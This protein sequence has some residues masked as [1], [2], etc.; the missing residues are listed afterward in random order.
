MRRIPNLRSFVL[1]AWCRGAALRFSGEAFERLA[2]AGFFA[3]TVIGPLRSQPLLPQTTP[4]PGIPGYRFPERE[5]TLLR[6]V[7]GSNSADEG[8]RAAATAKIR[9]HGWGLWTALTMETAQVFGGQRLRIFET[10]TTP[11][12]LASHPDW[13]NTAALSQRQRRRAPLRRLAQFQARPETDGPVAPMAS[14]SAGGRIVGFVKFD[15]TAADHLLA[16][17]LLHT[18]TLDALLQNGAQQVPVFPATALAVKSVF[19]IIK[20]SDLVDG[21]YYSLKAWPGPPDLPQPWGPAQWQGCVWIDLL[22]GGTGNGA[23]DEQAWADGGSRTTDTTY[24]LSS[25]INYRLSADDA[26]ALN[27]E[28]PGTGA[29]VG[30]HAI[31]VAMHIS[32]R[33]LARWTWQTF[34]WTPAPEAPNAPSS[35][36]IASLRPDQ[37]RGAARNYAMAQAYAML[38]PDQPYVGGENVGAGVYAYNPWIEARFGPAD[39]PDSRPGLDPAGRPAGNNYGVQTNCMSCH[40]QATYNPNKRSTAPRFTGARY[41]DLID[42][43]YVGTLQ[44]DFLWSLP[45]TAVGPCATPPA[46]PQVSVFA[47]ATHVPPVFPVPDLIPPLRHLPIKP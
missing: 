15:P 12:E 41:V 8:E 30:D 38:E 22:E 13:R 36:A 20:A 27:L 26:T 6:W 10:W 11:E 31:L 3:M 42:P 45:R 39:L 35:E 28:K 32:G 7:A 46:A 43:Q 1:P 37:L 5:A 47:P 44:V 18:D 33:E 2:L 24:P 16:Q 21:R 34:W 25:L 17:G 29:Q 4:D 14:D 19:Q 23:V 9:L 40:E